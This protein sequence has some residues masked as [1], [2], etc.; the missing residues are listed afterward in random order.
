MCVFSIH[1]PE[2]ETIFQKQQCIY[3][4]FDPTAEGLHFGN[5]LILMSLLHFLR[6]GHQVVCLVGNGTARIGDPSDKAGER[7]ALC[8]EAIQRNSAAVSANISKIFS[9]HYKYIWLSS[10]KRHPKPSQIFEPIILH[11]LDW[12]R[13][14]NVIDFIST[15]GRKLRLSDMLSRKFVA[16]RVKSKEGLSFTEFSYQVFQGYDWFHLFNQYNCKFQVREFSDFKINK[17]F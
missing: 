17:K 2:L 13:N 9:N 16:D 5:L 1:R 10:Q 4:G 6:D 8:E 7:P 3:A 14:R 11:N 12:Y 15:V